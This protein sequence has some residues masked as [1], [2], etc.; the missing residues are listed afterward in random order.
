MF[1]ICPCKQYNK[2]FETCCGP[3]IVGHK[4]AELPCLLMAS[5]YTAYVLRDWDY[6]IKTQAG[7]AAQR[8]NLEEAKE[9][10]V[11]WLNLKII[12][13]TMSVCK[14]KATVQ[15]E[16]SFSYQGKI[17]SLKEKSQ[18]ECILE[19]WYYTDQSYD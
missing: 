9:N 17:D 16:A 13:E 15:F 10:H 8:F 12:S 3:Y 6:I 2:T 4:K 19:L 7:V 11:E 18:F 1:M 5:R 14:H